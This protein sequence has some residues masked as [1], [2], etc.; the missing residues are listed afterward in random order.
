MNAR[1][2][3][4]YLS[5]KKRGDGTDYILAHGNVTGHKSL[6][7]TL[8]VHTTQIKHMKVD[9][10]TGEVM[11]QTRNTEYHCRLSECDFSRPDTYDMIPGLANYAERFGK[12][13]EYQQEDNSIL[14]VLSDHGNYYFETMIIKENGSLYKGMLYPH[15]GTLQ[16]SCL[17]SCAAHEGNID[18]RYFPHRQ[19]LRAYCWETGGLPVY[20]ENTG[21]DILY[22]TTKDGPIELRPGERK[23]ASKENAIG[24][25]A[26]LVL[27]QS[28]LYPAEKRKDVI[29]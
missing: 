11:I 14:L 24:A 27:D 10:E 18:I 12:E 22:F 28:D 21:D 3:H 26:R 2:H 7:D 23:L 25:D 8:Q 17:L 19:H 6:P 29:L 5:K 16:D 4:W 13:K 9:E 15:I 20:L 1:L